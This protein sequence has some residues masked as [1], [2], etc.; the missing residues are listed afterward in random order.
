MGKPD[1]PHNRTMEKAL[2]VLCTHPGNYYHM[3]IEFLGKLFAYFRKRRGAPEDDK[4]PTLPA[5]LTV[6]VGSALGPVIEEA[7]ALLF[8]DRVQEF[9]PVWVERADVIQCDDLYIIDICTPET[10]E[11][12][13]P[14]LWDT[15]TCPTPVLR[16][17]RQQ[18]LESVGLSHTDESKGYRAIYVT[19]SEKARNRQVQNQLKTIEKLKEWAAEKAPELHWQIY[20]EDNP[21]LIDQVRLF[22]EAAMVI[23]PHGAALTNVLYAPVGCKLLE[24]PTTGHG[25]RL[26]RWICNSVGHGHMFADDVQAL[27][28]DNYHVDDATIDSVVAAVDALWRGELTHSRPRPCKCEAS[29]D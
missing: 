3:V 7:L 14:S 1:M 4:E 18:I 8:P 26:H 24:F 28:T 16:E 25:I 11:P 6:C 27:Y 20:E 17:V 21:T 5:P 23:G 2:V 9:K 29:F 15:M 10:L 12:P 22:S 19:R 13:T